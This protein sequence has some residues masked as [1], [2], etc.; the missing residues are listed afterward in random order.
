MNSMHFFVHRQT[1]FVS[2]WIPPFMLDYKCTVKRLLIDSIKIC[3]LFHLT[4]PWTSQNLAASFPGFLGLLESKMVATSAK[5]S[6]VPR[7]FGEASWITASTDPGDE[8]L[9]NWLIQL[10]WKLLQNKYL[11]LESIRC[12]RPADKYKKERCPEPS[13]RI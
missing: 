3:I 10:I 13:K 4:I 6:L 5:D 8:L 7:N 9:L 11:S 2:L 12:E 1:S